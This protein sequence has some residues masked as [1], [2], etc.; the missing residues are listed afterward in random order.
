LEVTA[1]SNVR[2]IVLSPTFWPTIVGWIIVVLGGLLVAVRLAQPPL[3][4]AA[5]ADDEAEGGAAAWARL[6]AAAVVMVGLVLATSMLGMVWASMIAFALLAVIIRSPHP[7]S[8]A[9]VAVV[10]PLVLYAF[11]NHV[12]GVA[13][14]QG[15]FI[16]LP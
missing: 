2:A 6:G 12:A 14:P 4:G 3:D 11:F 8:S 7:V 15:E 1:P 10:L 16:R 9:I 13:V 5:G